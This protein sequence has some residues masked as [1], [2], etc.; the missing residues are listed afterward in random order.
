MTYS[1]SL[2]LRH[3]L[4]TTFIF[5]LQKIHFCRKNIQYFCQAF[6]LIMMSLSLMDQFLTVKSRLL[7][8]GDIHPHPGP[9]ELGLKFCHWNLNGI[10]A[11]NKIKI[12][13]MEA[14]NTVLYYDIIALSETFLNNTFKG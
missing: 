11:R 8:S 7:I 3:Q 10:L 6:L 14:C 9:F 12:P 1:L 13:L 2:L 4:T 5:I